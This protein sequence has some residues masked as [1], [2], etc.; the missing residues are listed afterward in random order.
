MNFPFTNEE[1]AMITKE[2]GSLAKLKK[3]LVSIQKSEYQSALKLHAEPMK[4]IRQIVTDNGISPDHL[5]TFL[6]SRQPRDKTTVRIT[7]K[8]KNTVQTTPDAKSS[9]T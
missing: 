1:V 6:S 7:R 9:P 2:T 5:I 3:L 4:Q 8:S